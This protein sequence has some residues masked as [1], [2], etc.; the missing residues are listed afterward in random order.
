[1]ACGRINVITKKKNL[2]KEKYRV[3][4]KHRFID[5]NA[6]DCLS[7]SGPAFAGKIDGILE[8]SIILRS[9]LLQA[10]WDAA[11]LPAGR[12]KAVKW[13]YLMAMYDSHARM[14]DSV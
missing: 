3:F 4:P 14:E 12:S 8:R 9:V 10:A 5:T 6:L 2:G 1:M 11:A 13:L 7:R